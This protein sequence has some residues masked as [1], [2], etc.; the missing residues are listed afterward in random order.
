M[1]NISLLADI[2]E[3]EVVDQAAK[4]ATDDQEEV[5]DIEEEIVD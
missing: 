4:E 3:E 5:V 2:E 1:F